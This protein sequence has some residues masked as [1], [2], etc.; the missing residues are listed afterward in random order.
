MTPAPAPA[1][2]LTSSGRYP[3][4]VPPGGPAARYDTLSAASRGHV[5]SEQENCPPEQSNEPP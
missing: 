4:A 1:P 3:A 5:R 2:G